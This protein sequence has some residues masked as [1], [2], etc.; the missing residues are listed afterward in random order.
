MN[1]NAFVV[2]VILLLLLTTSCHFYKE[3]DKESFPTYSWNDGQ[4][5]VFTPTIED[6]AKTYQIMLGLRHHYGVQTKSFGV[7]IKMVSPS[8]KESSKDYDLKIKDENNKH[9]GSCAG[10]MCDLETVVFEDLK[11]EEVGEYRF[12]ISHKERG[13]RIPG[14]MEV[15]LIIDEKN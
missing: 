14:I 12:S 4:E 13:Y 9:I 15:G 3:Y 10:D 7:I 5:V 11:F 1:K 6:N 8:G 2:G